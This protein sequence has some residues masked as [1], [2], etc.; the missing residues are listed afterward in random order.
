VSAAERPAN[1][2]AAS[3]PG[4][5]IY[6]LGYRHYDGPRRGRLYAMWALY[7]DSF[8]GVWGLG[9]QMSAK[10]APFILAG[11]YAFP[12]FIQLAFSSTIAASIQNGESPTLFAYHNYFVQLSPF[13][14]LFCVAQ[15]PELVCRDQRY[16]VLPLYFTR[17]LR[18]PDYA[19]ARLASLVTALFLLLIVP[20]IALFIG[21]VLQ[22]PDTFSAIGSELPKALPAIPATLLT[23]ASMAAISLALSAY[24]PR[25][26]YSAIGLLAYFL[27][28][29][30]IPATIYGVG[31]KAGWDWSDKLILTTPI[32]TLGGATNWF[33]G[34]TLGRGYP[35]T[36]GSG[37]Y[38]VAAVISILL[39]AAILM[40]R[41]RRI[42]A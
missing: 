3:S 21:N 13:A 20:M 33:F 37:P 19:L 27:L 39:F 31:Q 22:K 5:S 14:L 32:N 28:M 36:I 42:A 34:S 6:D 7:L 2:R 11:L 17:G 40:F 23:A 24:S 41:Y 35:A 16:Q 30:A 29:E 26:A 38:V 12:A 18:R 8:R 4:G 10:A 9:R 1:N 25:R 15:A